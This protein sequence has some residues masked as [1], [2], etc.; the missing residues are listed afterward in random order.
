MNNEEDFNN[1]DPERKPR[2]ITNILKKPVKRELT[3]EEKK[4]KEMSKRV[5][6]EDPRVKKRHKAES[7]LT[8]KK[9]TFSNLK[10]RKARGAAIRS[11][12]ELKGLTGTEYAELCGVTLTRISTI[13]TGAVDVNMETFDFMLSLLDAKMVIVHKKF[14]A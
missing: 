4:V 11:L 12:R 3:P 2:I 10:Q 6:R 5:N 9:G 1:L 7:R 13:E 14:I 8:E